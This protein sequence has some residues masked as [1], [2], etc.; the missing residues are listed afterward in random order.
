MRGRLILG[1]GLCAT[2]WLGQIA[3]PGPAKSRLRDPEVLLDL[4]GSFS[5]V[6]PVE[7]NK[8]NGSGLLRQPVTRKGRREEALVLVAPSSVRAA[9]S[10]IT[11]AADFEALAAPVFNIGDGT[12]LE[13]FL[14]DARGE[15]RVYE[16]LFDAGGRDSDRNWR[17]LRIPIDLG[18]G[19]QWQ[20]EMRVSAGS[21]GDLVGDWLAV[22][23]VQLR[24]RE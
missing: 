17:A 12:K 15:K 23:K 5:T 6:P 18:A 3:C 2:L 9:F 11:G 22:A 20:I 4:S 21:R 7:G 1:G 13:I 10:G 8:Q 16:G 19:G 14:S 24:R